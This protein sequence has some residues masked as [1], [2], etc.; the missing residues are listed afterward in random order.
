VPESVAILTVAGVGSAKMCAAAG[1]AAAPAPPSLAMLKTGARWWCWSERSAV[2]RW[3][4]H[5]RITAAPMAT[6]KPSHPAAPP[7]ERY[8]VPGYMPAIV[9][10]LLP[11]THRHI[12]RVTARY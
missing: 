10:Q 8:P 5:G 11:W 3:L 9:D 6:A 12:A 2:R 4:A 1:F 7:A